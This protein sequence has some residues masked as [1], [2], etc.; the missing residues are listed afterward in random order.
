[1]EM[2]NSDKQTKAQI[3]KTSFSLQPTNAMKKL[4]CFI[5]G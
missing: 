3:H 5:T 2:A 4:D 1:M